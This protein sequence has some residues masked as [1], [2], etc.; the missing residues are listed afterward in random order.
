MTFACPSPFLAAP[1]AWV[2]LHSPHSPNASLRGSTREG[3]RREAA[4][5]RQRGERERIG[6]TKGGRLLVTEGLKRDKGISKKIG[7]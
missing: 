7:G 2:I 1:V 3:W 6:K 4:L 5:E